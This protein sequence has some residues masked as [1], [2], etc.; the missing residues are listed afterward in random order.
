MLQLHREKL[1]LYYPVLKL[2]PEYISQKFKSMLVRGRSTPVPPNSTLNVPVK[3]LS[4]YLLK[5]KL[6]SLIYTLFISLN[7]YLY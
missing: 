1:V 3:L 6:S 7:N 5:K 2:V 4:V